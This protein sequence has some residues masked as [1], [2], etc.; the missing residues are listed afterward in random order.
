MIQ[1]TDEQI[2]RWLNIYAELPLPTEFYNIEPDFVQIA[3]LQADAERECADM[4][5]DEDETLLYVEKKLKGAFN[6]NTNDYAH[7]TLK[8]TDRGEEDWTEWLSFDQERKQQTIQLCAEAHNGQRPWANWCQQH[9]YIAADE[10]LDFAVWSIEAGSTKAEGTKAEGT[11]AESTKAESTKAEGT[12][13]VSTKNETPNTTKTPEQ[14]QGNSNNMG[15]TTTP[16][17]TTTATTD[18][19]QYFTRYTDL[20]LADGSKPFEGK[21][22]YRTTDD[23]KYAICEVFLDDYEAGEQGNTNGYVRMKYALTGPTHKMECYQMIDGFRYEWS[24][25]KAVKEMLELADPTIDQ[26]CNALTKPCAARFR[27]MAE[28]TKAESTKAE[29]TKAESTKAAEQHESESTKNEMPFVAYWNGNTADDV[30]VTWPAQDDKHINVKC[31]DPANG[32]ALDGEFLNFDAKDFH[33][34]MNGGGIRVWDNTDPTIIAAAKAAGFEL[35]VT[36]SGKTAEGTKAEGTKAESTKAAEQHE[37][38]ARKAAEEEAKRKAAEE[39]AAA[40]RAEQERKEREEREAAERAAAEAERERIEREK[41]AAAKAAEEA[42]RKDKAFHPMFDTIKTIL[43]LGGDAVYAYGPAGTGKTHMAVQL[44]EEFGLTMTSNGCIYQPYELVGFV[45]ANGNY[46]ETPFVRSLRGGGVHLFDEFERSIQQATVICNSVLANGFIDLP[47]GERVNVHPDFH[48]FACGNTNGEGATEDYG[49]AQKFEASTLDRF[50]T[51]EV[52]YDEAVEMKLAYGDKEMVEFIHAMRAAIA[53]C[54]YKHPL[55]Y[56]AYNRLVK[57]MGVFE[58]P[59]AIE[60]AIVRTMKKDDLRIVC[61]N[62]NCHNKYAEALKHVARNR[63]LSK[64]A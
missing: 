15:T 12:K 27:K 35:T 64:A 4:G 31:V 32:F 11:K 18:L 26:I 49:T 21:K 57:F 13:A 60:L 14:E 44:A 34:R 37:E 39:K 3:F 59:K 5:M 47:N 24:G 17:A 22:V 6:F 29:G 9:G 8:R 45:D 28:G 33:N 56:R 16:T 48:L 63:S 58:L 1:I 42:K 52:N 38:A 50:T 41:I 36:I 53:E 23:G 51:I 20:T 19:S 2:T 10:A 55:T 46:H 7:I 54:R 43:S 40:E 25:A 30:Y 62:L 61:S